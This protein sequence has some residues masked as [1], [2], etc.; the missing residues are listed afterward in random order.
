MQKSTNIKRWIYLFSLIVLTFL[1]I[2]FQ[3]PFSIRNEL[4]DKRISTFKAD[5]ISDADFIN[6]I[7]NIMPQGAMIYQLPFHRFPESHPKND[8]GDYRLIIGCQLSKNLKW[9][10]AA[11]RGRYADYWH[12]KIDSFPL[13]SKLKILSLVGFEGIYI[14]RRAYTFNEINNLER[15]LSEILDTNCSYSRDEKLSF[16]DMNEFNQKQR[17]D[18]SKNELIEIKRQLIENID[19]AFLL[20]VDY[21][22]IAE[23][24]I[25]QDIN[26]LK[27]NSY[28]V[29]FD[30]INDNL[31]LKCGNLDPQLSI[32]LLN[33][34]EKNTGNPFVEIIYTT[35]KSGLLQ[36]FYN[37]GNG[38]SEQN[39]YSEFINSTNNEKTIQIPIVGWEEGKQLVGIRIDPPN[40]TA[41]M[42]KNISIITL[43]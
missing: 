1:N 39:S 5:Y 15:S 29:D 17:Y 9:S 11:M 43:K 28:D 20:Y 23:L 36:I 3:Y 6:S 41:F 12:Q 30:I 37:Y 22:T 34:A 2:F 38:L 14:D 26:V 4:L 33:P 13:A 31:V 32:Q 16:F 27:Q 7:E 10:Y 18:Y 19:E 25:F 40:D 42:L 21:N 35:S 8:M 24:S